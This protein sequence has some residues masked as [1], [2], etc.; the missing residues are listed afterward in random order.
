[1]FRKIHLQKRYL[2][3]RH[4]SSRGF[5]E[6]MKDAM[7]SIASGIAQVSEPENV[8]DATVIMPDARRNR[9]SG[10]RDRRNIND[11]GSA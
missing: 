1:M 6:A 5:D 3:S 7:S 2:L 11:G 8:P 9:K 10:T 4:R